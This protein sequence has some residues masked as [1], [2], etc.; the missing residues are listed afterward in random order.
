MSTYSALYLL[1]VLVRDDLHAGEPMLRLLRRLLRHV[2][3]VGADG[4]GEDGAVGDFASVLLGVGEN[5][6]VG[7]ALGVETVEV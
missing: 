6:R 2:F 4:I 1:A 7:T 3:V 5:L